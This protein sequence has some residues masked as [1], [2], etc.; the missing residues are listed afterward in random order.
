MKMNI[1]L[2]VRADELREI[3]KHIDATIKIADE[4]NSINEQKQAALIELLGEEKAAKAIMILFGE[5]ETV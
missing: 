1:P 4:I 3:Q 2:L 5:Y